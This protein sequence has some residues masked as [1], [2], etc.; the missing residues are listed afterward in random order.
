MQF[1]WN[2]DKANLNLKNHGVS[3]TEA[4]TVFNDHLSTTYGTGQII[5]NTAMK[6]LIDKT[7]QTN[8][9]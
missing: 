9:D 2:P 7:L 3:F 8:R 4:S 5:S 6:L 1:K